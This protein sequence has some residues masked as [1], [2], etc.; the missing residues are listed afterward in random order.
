MLNLAGIAVEGESTGGLGTCIRLPGHGVVLDIGLC[1]RAAIPIPTVLVSHAHMDHLGCLAMHCATR[2]LMA[3]GPPTYVLPEPLLPDVEALLAAWRQLDGSRL[4]CRL[5][6]VRPGQSVPLSPTTRVDVLPALHR[7]PSVGYAI[8]SL[9]HKLRPEYLD[10]PGHRIRELKLAGEPVTDPFWSADVAFTGDTLLEVIDMDPRFLQARLLILETTFLD[11]R[12]S[13][14][15][16]RDKGHVHLDEVIAREAC[17]RNRAILMTHFSAR[18]TH[19]EVRALLEQRL[20]PTL[21]ARITP[22]LPPA[23]EGKALALPH[24]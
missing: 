13:V 6:P 16:C 11:D 12:V 8:M 20:P 15:A 22:L 7:P 3:M 9:K 21:K 19:A 14:E 17:F 4:P 1:P 10:L 23:S 24:P 5:V 18:Y 2:S